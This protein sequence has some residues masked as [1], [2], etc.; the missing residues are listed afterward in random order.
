MKSLANLEAR[1]GLSHPVRMFA[2]SDEV[3][4]VYCGM[5]VARRW[6]ARQI[7]PPLSSLHAA[8]AGSH[9]KL[10][11]GQLLSLR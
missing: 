10:Q 7:D 9:C 4:V 3:L 2:G 5:P 6:R 1:E 11:Q 8:N